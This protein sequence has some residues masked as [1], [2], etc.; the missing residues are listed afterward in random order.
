MQFWR[1]GPPPFNAAIETRYGLLQRTLRLMPGREVPAFRQLVVMNQVGMGFL[2]PGARRRI[3]LVGEDTDA[4][5]E[6]DALRRKVSQ[7]IGQEGEFA[8]ATNQGWRWCR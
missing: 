8:I 7:A 4:N 5:R 1:D 6:G 3:Q 2:G